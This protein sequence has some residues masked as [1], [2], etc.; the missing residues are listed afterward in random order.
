LKGR[1]YIEKLL[2]D[3]EIR[4][5][6]GEGSEPIG[7]LYQIS[8]R[9]T[10]GIKLEESIK[11]IENGISI[12][13]DR[14]KEERNHLFK[15]TNIEERIEDAYAL[16][17]SASHLSTYTATQLLSILRLASAERLIHIPLEK[18]DILLFLIRPTAIQFF[19]G[20]KMKVEERDKQ[21]ANL[22][23][24]IILF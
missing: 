8:T 5:L 21:R 23:R 13:E 3:M 22:L 1:D 11:E 20:R 10:L 9:R 2:A 15:R 18:I 19:S 24:E 12:I 16:I 4:G 17:S 6:L 7:F 14:E